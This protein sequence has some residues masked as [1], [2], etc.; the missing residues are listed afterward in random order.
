[1][2]NTSNSLAA[3]V[4]GAAATDRF[5]ERPGGCDEI[6]G[7]GAESGE[8]AWEFCLGSFP[9]F[10]EKGIFETQ[11]ASCRALRPWGLLGLLDAVVRGR[12]IHIPLP[13]SW[14]HASVK[15]ICVLQMEDCSKTNRTQ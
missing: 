8:G 14:S 7:K 2:V 10:R 12:R 9:T 11:G 6:L 13:K 4:L 1:M 5:A 15:N 3:I